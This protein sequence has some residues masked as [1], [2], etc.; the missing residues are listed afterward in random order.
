MK[1]DYQPLPLQIHNRF[2][3]IFKKIFNPYRSLALGAKR[4]LLKRFRHLSIFFYKRQFE[5]GQDYKHLPLQILNR[6]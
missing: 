2:F 5:Y 3:Q 1:K 4:I 6:F